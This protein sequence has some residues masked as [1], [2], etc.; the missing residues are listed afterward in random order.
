MSWMW[1]IMINFSLVVVCVLIFLWWWF[2]YLLSSGGVM[3]ASF[4]LVVGCVPTF[5]W[6]WQTLKLSLIITHKETSAVCYPGMLGQV[7]EH[8]SISGWILTNFHLNNI[9]LA[10]KLAELEPGERCWRNTWTEP[11][12]CGKTGVLICWGGMIIILKNWA[13][14][15]S[16]EP[17][18]D[19]N[20]PKKGQQWPKI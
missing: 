2:T 5:L 8:Q 18:L 6:W 20:E 17:K 14:N 11:D 4:P 16:L 12:L 7:W 15:W 1:P 10:Q 19:R 9:F 13:E 3:Y